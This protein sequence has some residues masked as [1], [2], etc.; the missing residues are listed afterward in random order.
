MGGTFTRYQ[1]IQSD[2]VPVPSSSSSSSCDS[3][4]LVSQFRSSTGTS[5]TPISTRPRIRQCQTCQG[6]LHPAFECT[7]CTGVYCGRCYYLVSVSH[8]R[9]F[10]LDFCNKYIIV[11]STPFRLLQRSVCD[12][13]LPDIEQ[14]NNFR[15]I[16]LPL[17]LHSLPN[18]PSRSLSF[19]SNLS[20]NKQ[21]TVLYSTPLLLVRTSVVPGIP[22][23]VRSVW[24]YLDI[25]T[26]T[27]HYRS[28]Q[29]QNQ[30]P[31]DKGCIPIDDIAGIQLGNAVTSAVTF[32]SAWLS[33]SSSTSNTSS[34]TSP[35][36]PEYLIRLVNSRGHTL[37]LLNCNN[38]LQMQTWNEALSS[39]TIVC[40][41]KY[42]R[43]FPKTNS[44]DDSTVDSNS[45]NST[46]TATSGTVSSDVSELKPS[47][48]NNPSEDRK[49]E[50]ARRQAERDAFRSRIGPVGMQ[51]TA[52]IL[53]DKQQK[54]SSPGITT[55]ATTV[56]GNTLSSANTSSSSS[57]SAVSSSRTTPTS[58]PPFGSLPTSL[59][60]IISNVA[61]PPPSAL[62][63]LQQ[64]NQMNRN[65]NTSN[66]FTR[67][68]ISSSSSASSG[69]G[70]TA[71]KT[72]NLSTTKRE[73]SV[74]LQ[75]FQSGL[76]SIVRK[77][78]TGGN[79]SSSSNTK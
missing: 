79:I 9:S 13:C 47:S 11:F 49:T 7:R 78:T 5:A 30:E 10:I 21:L 6:N 59:R 52:K 75:S 67:M 69:T 62:E 14:E 12:S 19:L 8:Y 64:G 50:M 35:I 65:N 72:L 41:Q 31:V 63:I 29:L 68:P 58:T 54:Q 2:I 44:S 1:P 37:F 27:L 45:T 74:R 23:T 76:G 48:T 24:I 15:C 4:S 57:S 42:S 55:T 26:R 77:A 22:P 16:H 38:K 66:S 20:L 46:S 3:S 61:K 70:S 36:K 60:T 51:N 33:S 73:L 71:S 32:P 40:K 25:S 39:L 43:I 56:T 17:L 34:P 28:I 53:M 18:P